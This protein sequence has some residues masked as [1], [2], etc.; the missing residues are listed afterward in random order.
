MKFRV[1]LVSAATAWCAAAA[2]FS[3]DDT[4]ANRSAALRNFDSY[5]AALRSQGLK[6]APAD[7]IQGRYRTQFDRQLGLPTF[8]WA[9]GDEAIP[10]VGALQEKSLLEA[11][12]R[13]Y[14]TA[15]AGSLGVDA[16]QVQDAKLAMASYN[17]RGPAVVKFRQQRNGVEVLRREL[18]VMMDRSGRLVAVSGYFSSAAESAPTPAAFLRSPQQAISTAFASLGGTLSAS[19]LQLNKRQGEY[20]WYSFP[21]LSGDRL[22]TRQPRAKR[23]YYPSP[24]GLVPG[25]YVELFLQTSTSSTQAAYGMVI[26]AVDNSVLLR[27]DLVSRAEYSYR[28]FAEDSGDY[29]PFDM[30]LGNEYAPFPSADPKEKLE[31]KSPGSRLV[32]LTHGPISTGDPWIAEDG[33]TTL[34]GN[35][36][37]AYLDNGINV[38]LPVYLTNANDPTAEYIGLT[39]DTRASNTGP[40]SFDHPIAADDDPATAGAKDAANVTLFFINNWMHDSWY[41]HGLDEASGNAQLVNYDR[42]GVEADPIQAQGQDSSGRGNANMAAPSDGNRPVMQMYLFNGPYIGEARVTA[43]FDSGPLPVAGASF[44]PQEFDV[45]AEVAVANSN[46]CSPATVTDPVVGLVKVTVPAVPDNNLRGK[47]ALIDRGECNNTVKEQFAMLSGAAMMVMVNNTPGEPTAMGNGDIPVA[48]PVVGG[49]DRVYTVPAVRISLEDG[50]VI[51]D[52]VAAGQTVTM[53]IH[54]TPSTDFDGTLDHQ[55]I[56][57]EFFHYASNRLVGNSTGLGNNQGGGMGEGWSDVAAMILTVRPEDSKI[58]GNEQYQGAYGLA[59][60]VQNNFYKGIRR[61]PYSTDFAHNAYTFKHIAEAEPTPG[62]GNGVG[63]SEVHAT[64]EIWANMVWGCYAGLLNEHG[65][66]EGQQRIKD[67]VI[68]GLKMTPVDPT[69]TEARD[70]ILAAALGTD[71]A[72][73]AVCGHSFAV[74]GAGLNAQS[75]ERDSADNVGVVEDY[76]EFGEPK[77]RSVESRFGGALGLALL[78]PLLL[79]GSRRR[80]KS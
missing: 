75:P 77:A 69:I 9:K 65:F 14:L 6:S 71:A 17:G 38:S 42:G 46:G 44:G 12:A 67:Y 7:L 57:H 55:I 61:A 53:R 66:E 58:K 15:Y 5:S 43:P 13:Q 64:G 2:A 24:R 20:E 76:T 10:A 68:A 37:N 11:R 56:A 49:T 48:L 59:G 50:Q 79:V 25:Y 19:A 62:G 47:I 27:K 51:K 29:H 54:R 1:F 45:T 35:N 28:V 33:A 30:P 4:P 39:G 74:R 80:R 16:T 73:V 21:A 8:I 34:T 41:D 31:R 36:T 40:N 70:G 23:V 63:N 3:G 22:L 72:D 18:N 60:Y 78:L 26:S 52:A 32:T